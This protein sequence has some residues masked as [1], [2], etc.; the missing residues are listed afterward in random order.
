M[1]I[2][3]GDRLEGCTDTPESRRLHAH[4]RAGTTVDGL[5]DGGRRVQAFVQAD[6]RSEV[7]CQLAMALEVV[8]AEGLLDAGE[9]QVVE[10]PEPVGGVGSVG[11]VGIK[12]HKEVAIHAVHWRAFFAEVNLFV[13]E[14]AAA[15]SSI[16]AFARERTSD[17]AA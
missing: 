1:G 13:P 7:G 9:T 8:S 2:A 14:C 16:S 17:A 5:D 3:P 10:D 12:L 11:T 4:D 6:R 15:A